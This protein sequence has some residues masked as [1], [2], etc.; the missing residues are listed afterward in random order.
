MPLHK[1]TTR[2]T[3]GHVHV[4][5]QDQPHSQ[6]SLRARTRGNCANCP[7]ARGAQA[8]PLLLCLPVIIVEQVLLLFIEADGF[9]WM[10]FLIMEM[11]RKLQNLRIFYV[12]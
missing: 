5:E 7:T 8:T 2:R 11:C 4:R 3:H 1:Q 12:A 10:K 9:F 6:S